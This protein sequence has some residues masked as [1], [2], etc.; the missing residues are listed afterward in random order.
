MPSKTVPR[1]LAGAM[2]SS[3]SS[4]SLY[5]RASAF[6]SLSRASIESR[7]AFWP[8]HAH[9]TV[10][11]NAKREVTFHYARGRR[12]LSAFPAPI[13]VE[14]AEWLGEKARIAAPRR[15]VALRFSARNV[16][17]ASTQGTPGVLHLDGKS[18]VRIVSDAAS[19]PD[20][21]LTV[22]GWVWAES[23]KGR[24]PFINKTEE[25]E[26]GIFMDGGRARFIIHL[27]GRYV[28]AMMPEGTTLEPRRWHHLAGVFDGRSV[29]LYVDGREVSR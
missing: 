23:L 6:H 9:L 14:Q 17:V 3:E 4:G 11:P 8:D 13:I 12:G 5:S 24:R 16:V 15:S 7:V 27:G 18:D 19:P 21:P 26:Y 29:R 20:G 2:S 10:Q 22:E 25:S 28:E 1:A